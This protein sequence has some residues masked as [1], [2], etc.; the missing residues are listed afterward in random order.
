MD[1]LQ[2]NKYIM[3]WGVICV[4]LMCEAVV[5]KG[6]SQ[7]ISRLKAQLPQIKDSTQYVDILNR[8][9]VL[10]LPQNLDTCIL[11]TN[12]ARGIAERQAYLKGQAWV[13]MNQGNYY[14]LSS[15]SFLSYRSYLHA[16]RAYEKLGDSAAVCQA[17]ANM[18]IYYKY[19]G[20][21]A[22][23]VQY[24]RQAMNKSR[25]VRNDSLYATVLVSYYYVHADDTLHADSVQWAL[26]KVRSLANQY[27]DERTQLKC[28]LYEANERMK[29]GDAAGA[30]KQLLQIIQQADTNGYT[31]LAM[32]ACAQLAGYKGY[33]K[34][35]DSLQYKVSMVQYGVAGGYWELILP[36]TTA[37]YTFYTQHG[38]PAAAARYSHLMLSI[39]EK[40]QA[41]RTQGELDY[42]AYY[43]QN[44]RLN[45]LQLQHRLQQ[46]K[47]DQKRLENR[48]RQYLVGGMVLSLVLVMLLLTFFYYAYKRSREN[49][50]RFTEKYREISE[51]NTLLQTHDDFKNKLI[52]LIAHDFRMPLVNILEIM[53]FLQAHSLGPEEAASLL[54]GVERS[55]RN[56]LHTF[57]SIL[58]WINSQLS[59]FV[60]APEP[61]RVQELVNVALQSLTDVIS[62]KQ[63]QVNVRI[64]GNVCVLAECEMLQFVHRNFIHNALKFSPRH[65][66]IYVTADINEGQVTITVT[67][68]G[69]GIPDHLLP[70][71]F[72]YHA[73][74]PRKGPQQGAGLA[75]IICRD[76]MNMMKGSVQA[77]NTSGRGAA[78]SYTL[79]QVECKDP[80]TTS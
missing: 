68:E 12:A 67:D 72:E 60:Y 51:K 57:D 5:L 79:P 78:L 9:S 71:L 20:Q 8:L 32:Y 13:W 73:D 15:N 70:H 75:L 59:G 65:S 23:A 29:K 4:W 69:L 24:M 25:S 11:Y 30:E 40:E 47:L 58:R 22:S 1:H 66:S 18:A 3:R 42:M 26:A 10:Y 43:Q 6:Q 50:M 54:T 39:L 33:F 74:R 53:N 55:S 63:V 49:G 37:L 35:P 44:G 31:Y 7:E 17:L 21:Q 27:H 19:I 34:Q 28:G 62:E 52:S 41:A 48:K 64:P 36:M 56:T 14:A 45:A 80:S 2:R 76:F 38:Q 61:C 46:A 77:A 16:L